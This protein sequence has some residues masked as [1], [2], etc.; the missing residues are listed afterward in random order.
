MLGIP[1]L[2]CKPL[3]RCLHSSSKVN[4]LAITAGDN[5]RRWHW[6]LAV[7]GQAMEATLIRMALPTSIP[8]QIRYIVYLE[9][10]GSWAHLSQSHELG[11]LTTSSLFLLSSE[12]RPLCINAC[13]WWLLLHLGSTPTL[14]CDPNAAKEL[15]KTWWVCWVPA[16]VKINMF[17]LKTRL[18]DESLMQE[19]VKYIKHVGRA[20]TCV[21]EFC[22]THGFKR[23]GLQFSIH[24]WDQEAESV[25]ILKFNSN[26]HDSLDPK[27]N[28]NF[29]YGIHDSINWW[30]KHKRWKKSCNGQLRDINTPICMFRQI[31]VGHSMHFLL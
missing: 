24:R 4:D 18:K 15:T 25:Q 1:M 17:Y 6:T 11:K 7:T 28:S 16:P 22:N 13:F 27:R 3:H 31:D 2:E 12:M 9:S 30:S 14:N 10:A 26:I 20:R 23:P 19:S 5:P 29:V 21:A 8:H